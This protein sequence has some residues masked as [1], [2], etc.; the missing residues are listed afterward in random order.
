MENTISPTRMHA[1]SVTAAQRLDRLPASRFHRKLGFLIGAGMF[2]DGFDLLMIGGLMPFMIRSGFVTPARVP[3]LISYT[4]AGL[5]IGSLLAGYLGD[6]FGRKLLYQFNLI[7]YG[8]ASLACAAAPNYDF[9]LVARFISAIGMGGE[10]V[11]GYGF[12]GEFLPP[13]KRGSWG[14]IMALSTN[15]AYPIALAI[16]AVIVPTY[17]W[18]WMFVVAGLPVLAIGWLRRALP[19]SPRWLERAGNAEAADRVITAIEN[20]I[21]G[22]TGHPL[23]PIQAG[24]V[25]HFTPT[26]FAPTDLFKGW[27]AKRT[28]LACL[29]WL[30]AVATQ[31]GFITFTPMLLVKQ[32]FLV[33]T[34][35]NLSLIMS[36]G[37]IPGVVAGSFLADRWG[38][39]P[40]VICSALIAAALGVAIPFEANP[41]V[42]AVLGFCMATMI[43]VFIAVVVCV[44]VPELF[45][46]PARLSGSGFAT[47]VGR[48]GLI[49]LPLLMAHIVETLGGPFAFYVLSASS[50]CLAASIAVFGVETR[51]RSLEEIEFLGEGR[52][53]P[54]AT[55]QYNSGARSHVGQR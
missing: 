28:L 13:S 48:V 16:A 42:I 15:V 1:A 54:G 23:P 11:S 8:I 7:L 49:F 10:I 29:C 43:F 36:I 27:I 24:T 38:R 31:W 30:F 51:N 52:T 39:K 37:A 12:F 19:E 34:S 18:R 44:Y 9:L 50:V 5:L 25:E 47:G 6:R 22:E 20:Q 53:A 35:L 45:P 40:T 46:T 14:A 3:S 33:G 2:F 41:T 32:G 17:G 4:A 26:Q 21:E 55:S